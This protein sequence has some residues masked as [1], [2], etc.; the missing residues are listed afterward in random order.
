L[1]IVNLI[2]LLVCVKGR[3]SPD[4]FRAAPARSLQI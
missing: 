1:F 4:A 2:L 3:E